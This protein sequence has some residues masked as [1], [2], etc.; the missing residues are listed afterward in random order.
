[1]PVLRVILLASTLVAALSPAQAAIDSSPRPDGE[2]A[3]RKERP[4]TTTAPA[5]CAW[6]A[7]R[8]GSAS[9]SLAC[10]AG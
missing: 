2:R 10:H 1:M 6:I 9:N 5:G 7:L 4:Q 3:L 8:A